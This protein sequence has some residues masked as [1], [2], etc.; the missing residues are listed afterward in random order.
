VSRGRTS[1]PHS[2]NSQ[3]FI[4]FGDAPWF[5]W[6]YSV[7]GQVVGHGSC[8]RHQEGWRNNN[9]AISGVP[10]KIVKCAWGADAKG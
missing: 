3:F 7:W 9:G 4:C 10:D 1:D 2:A 8:R 5:D 6:Q